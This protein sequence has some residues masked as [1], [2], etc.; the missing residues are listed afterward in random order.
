MPGDHL[1]YIRV[2]RLLAVRRGWFGEAQEVGEG[3]PVAAPP[4]RVVQTRADGIEEDGLGRGRSKLRDAGAGRLGRFD[5][6]RD[7]SP[8]ERDG[9]VPFALEEQ[10]RRRGHVGTTRL[11]VV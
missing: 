8:I 7:G 1:G 9:P 2:R 6:R 3:V 10:I 11:K 4:V 5:E